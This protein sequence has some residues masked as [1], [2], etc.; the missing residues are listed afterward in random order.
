MFFSSPNTSRSQRLSTLP[1]DT[2]RQHGGALRRPALLLIGVMLALAAL[3]PATSQAAPFAYVTN[4]SGNDV[5]QYDSSGGGLLAPLSPATEPAGTSPGQVAI[6]PDGL[7]AYVANIDDGDISQ[8]DVGNWRPPHAQDPAHGNRRHEPDGCCREP[9][10]EQRLRRE[11]RQRRRLPVRRRRR[12]RSS[13]RRPRP[14]SPRA[15][16]PSSWR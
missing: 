3:W 10:R 1:D 14:P 11:S 2:G 16:Y 5:S 7:S 12:R 6:S 8:Y 15:A 13:R 9:G 4:N